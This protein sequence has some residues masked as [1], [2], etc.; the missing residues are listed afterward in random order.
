MNEFTDFYRRRAAECYEEMML[1]CENGYVNEFV[2][3]EREFE[4]Y[5]KAANLPENWKPNDET[6]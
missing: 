1:C 2:V 5:R 3:A 4:T 6:E